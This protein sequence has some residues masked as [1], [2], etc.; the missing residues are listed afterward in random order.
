MDHVMW[1]TAGIIVTLA[2]TIFYAGV[3]WG[4]IKTYSGKFDRVFKKLD[5][6]DKR[7]RKTSLILMA[8]AMK[9]G[10]PG[11]DDEIVKMV[12]SLGDNGGG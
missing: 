2:L 10:N 3:S 7:Y 12:K 5:E 1:Q 11:H 6:A 4:R 8:M 9:F